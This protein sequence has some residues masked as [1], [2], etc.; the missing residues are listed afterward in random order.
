MAPPKKEAGDAADEDPGKAAREY[1]NPTPKG[2][3]KLMDAPMQKAYQPHE[4]EASWNDWWEAQA[5]YR[6]ESSPEDKRP[7][8][9]ICLPPP[10]VTGALHIGHALTVAVQDLIARWRRMQGYNVLWIPGTDHAGIATQVVVEKQLAK[11]SPPLSRHD[12]GRE[13]FLEKVWEYKEE[14]HGRITGQLKRL[15]C[16][17]DWS[18][19]VF[20]LDEPRVHAVKAAFKKFYDDGLLYRDVRLTNWCCTLRS[21][22]SD[23]EVDYEDIEKRKR[24]TVPGHD[25]SKTYVFGVI[26]SF[27]YKLVGSDE[28]IVVAT[29]RPETMLGDVAIAVHPD[30]PRYKHYHGKFFQH[31]FVDR[32]LPLI[33]DSTL[34]DMNFG[35]GA[36]KITPAHDPNDFAAGRRHGLP[37]ITV[38][39]DDG[40]MAANCDQFAGMMRFDARDAVL[41]ALKKMGHFRGDADNKMRLGPHWCCCQLCWWSSRRAIRPPTGR[42]APAATP[43]ATATPSPPATPTSGLAATPTPAPTTPPRSTTPLRPSP[44]TSTSPWSR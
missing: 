19:E 34:V 24:F 5:Y 28:E 37:E 39:T 33:L 42:T 41:I 26:W 14:C 44:S 32:K 22:I 27:A 35:T 16:S 2:E 21:G 38:F 29:T 6:A 8:F 7:K 43:M 4:V 31:P 36:V 15:G 10:N 20:T 17:L 18:R 30:D 25:K 40:K 1:V 11:R 13:A 12:L 23:I 9:S 3:L